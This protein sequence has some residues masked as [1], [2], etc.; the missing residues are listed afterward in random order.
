M[1]FANN[2]G[3]KLTYI[4]K[5]SLEDIEQLLDEDPNSL[6]DLQE[7]SLA[8]KDDI[9]DEWLD[10]GCNDVP[11]LTDITE[12]VKS[13]LKEVKKIYT[14]QAFKAFVQLNAVLQFVKLRERYWKDN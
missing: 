8:S 3:F 5:E 7:V 1:I 11:R 4:N 2:S 9:I 12:I 10:E 13:C 14:P 6:H